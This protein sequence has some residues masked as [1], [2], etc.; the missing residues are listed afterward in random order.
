MSIYRYSP[1][2]GAPSK[3][4]KRKR[5]KKSLD[6]EE[7]LPHPRITIKIKPIPLPAG[8]VPSE[9]NPQCFYV[10]NEANDN[11]PPPF[12]MK[13]P[14]S[15]KRSPQ[16]RRKSP[17]KV[18]SPRA[19]VKAKSP[20]LSSPRVSSGNESLKDPLAIPTA[21]ICDVC[22]LEGAPS[23]SVKCDDC[24]KTYHFSCLEPPLKKS[25]KRRGYS[26]HCADCDPTASE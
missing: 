6:I 13:K 26:W 9:S 3:E 10:P 22:H 21:S 23:N 24:R 17:P 25:P 2:L 11:A 16:E 4:H 7:P 19:E 1:D 14:P 5:K 18:K 8:E 20:R 15:P 12:P